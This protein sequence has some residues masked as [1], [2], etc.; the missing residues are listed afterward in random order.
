MNL[1]V[2]GCS[3][4]QSS[5]SVREKLSFTPDQVKT[6]LNKFHSTFPLSEAVLISTCNRTE[7]YLPEKRSKV[8]RRRSR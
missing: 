4:H 3:H 6:F 2:I 8:S 7:L 5:V 1:H